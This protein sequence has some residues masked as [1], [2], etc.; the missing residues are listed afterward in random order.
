[1]KQAV[2]IIEKS[3]H[4]NLVATVSVSETALVIEPGVGPHC[5]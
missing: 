2:L 3:V 1:M 4:V 5:L